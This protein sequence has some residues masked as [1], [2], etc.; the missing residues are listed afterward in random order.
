[1]RILEDNGVN[2]TV[3]DIS[4]AVRDELGF[5]IIKE[6]ENEWYYRLGSGIKLSVNFIDDIEIILEFPDKEV[7]MSE[8]Y[9]KSESYSTAIESAQS[10]TD[11]IRRMTGEGDSDDNS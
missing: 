9:S 10:I 5:S 4:D 11:I 8:N 3:D 6:N 1:M 7:D 2:Y